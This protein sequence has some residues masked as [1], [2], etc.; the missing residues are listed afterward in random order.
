MS[1]KEEALTPEEQDKIKLGKLEKRWAIDKWKVQSVVKNKSNR[2]V[3]SQMK[4]DYQLEKVNFIAENI[5]RGLN[6][7]VQLQMSQSNA[8]QTMFK[9]IEVE[10][11]KLR[12]V[13]KKVDVEND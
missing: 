12:K 3:I 8:L 11:N 9:N 5:Y 2:D 4:R 6:S 1:G 13:T 7:I 10:L